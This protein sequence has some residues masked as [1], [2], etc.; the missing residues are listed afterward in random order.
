MPRAREAM[1]V[2]MHAGA[3]HVR[4]RHQHEHVSRSLFLQVDPFLSLYSSESVTNCTH[5]VKVMEFMHPPAVCARERGA[6]RAS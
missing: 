4:R 1:H 5:A 2:R 6:H 3:V